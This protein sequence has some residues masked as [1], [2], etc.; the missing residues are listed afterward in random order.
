MGKFTTST[1]SF[2]IAMLNHQRVDFDTSKKGQ[3]SGI[4]RF[5]SFTGRD[6]KYVL[7]FR[8]L[9]PHVLCIAVFEW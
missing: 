3:K 7:P 4:L 8:V 9:K 1:G 5:F 6:T 2:S